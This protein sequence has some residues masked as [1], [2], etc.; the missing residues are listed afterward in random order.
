MCV[1]VECVVLKLRFAVCS[2]GWRGG[3]GGFFGVTE[4]ATYS[5]FLPIKGFVHFF[6]YQD[7]HL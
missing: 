6:S 3:G 2:A 5:H 4:S 7:I 1:I